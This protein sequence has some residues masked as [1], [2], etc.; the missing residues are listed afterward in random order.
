[1]TQQSLPPVTPEIR[2]FLVISNVSNLAM[3]ISKELNGK[4]IN[5][6]FISQ[7]NSQKAGELTEAI[8][9][10]GT[11]ITKKPEMERALLN[12]AIQSACPL[13]FRKTKQA[14]I[15]SMINL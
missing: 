13:V 9:V 14:I 4:S 15:T 10:L 12:R 11:D 5:L 8:A 6:E 2:R 7:Y 1:M 3:L